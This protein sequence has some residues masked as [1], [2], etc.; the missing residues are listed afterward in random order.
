[1]SPQ[2]RRQNLAQGEASAASETLGNPG[3]RFRT[4]QSRLAFSRIIV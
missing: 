3:E 4:V 2:S 1:M